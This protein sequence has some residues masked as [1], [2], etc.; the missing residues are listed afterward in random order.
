MFGIMAL[1][2]ELLSR[3][4]LVSILS[5]A[6]MMQQLRLVFARTSWRRLVPLFQRHMKSIKLTTKNTRNHNQLFAQLVLIKLN[7][8]VCGNVLKVGSNENLQRTP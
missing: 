4:K 5:T 1:T 2:L 3:S 7:R 8:K 6:K